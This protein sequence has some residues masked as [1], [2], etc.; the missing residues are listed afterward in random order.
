MDEQAVGTRHIVAEDWEPVSAPPSRVRYQVLGS[1]CALAVVTY[2]HRLGFSYGTTEIK[3]DLGLDSAQVGY[4]MAAFLVAYG[5]F[6]IPGGVLGD[7]LGGRHVLTILVLGWSLL[8][9]AVALAVLLPAVVAVRFGYLLVV[10][11]LFGM[12]QAGGFPVLGRVMADWM[13]TTE[14]GFAQGSIWMF[15]RWGGALIPFLLAWLFAAC[16]GWPVPFVLIAVLGVLWCGAFWPWFR[17]RP[18]EMPLVN[19]G[20]RKL[21]EAGRPADPGPPGPVPWARML[22]SRSVWSLCL[23]YGFTGFAGNFFTSMLPLYLSEYRHL[24]IAARA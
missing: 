18:A 17:N 11:F 4:L 22:G 23:M 21:I 14:R 6:Q 13:P 12:F 3:Q 7:R 9:G 5:A 20:E 8:T 10:R 1:T 2:I 19:R 15:S 16:G 24:G